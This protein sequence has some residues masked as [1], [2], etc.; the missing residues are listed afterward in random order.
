MSQ[1]KDTDFNI[2]VFIAQ[3]EKIDNLYNTFLKKK[4]DKL[5]K[6]KDIS[7]TKMYEYEAYRN[8]NANY[9]L[10]ILFLIIIFIIIYKLFFIYFF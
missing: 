9:G 4:S 1:D 5:Y 6:L 3:P 2:P 10:L 7:V 8:Y